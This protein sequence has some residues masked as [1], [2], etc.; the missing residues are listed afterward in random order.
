MMMLLRIQ[1]EITEKEEEEE[2]EIYFPSL[3]PFNMTMDKKAFQY[4]KMRLPLSSFSW[5]SVNLGRK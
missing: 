4:N 3:P 5:D 2:D 1:R